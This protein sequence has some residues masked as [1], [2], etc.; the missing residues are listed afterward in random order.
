MQGAERADGLS[1][2][3]ERRQSIGSEASRGNNG[4]GADVGPSSPFTPMAAQHGGNGGGGAAAELVPEAGTSGRGIMA[5]TG[6]GGRGS[7]TGRGSSAGRASGR[8]SAGLDWSPS[9]SST[10]RG[11]PIKSPAARGGRLGGGGGVTGRRMLYSIT[12]VFITLATISMLLAPSRSP[13]ALSM[14]S[15]SGSKQVSASSIVPQS[16]T[17]VA[18]DWRRPDPVVS[19]TLSLHRESTRQ[20][21][22]ES[23]SGP[24]ARAIGLQAHPCRAV[25]TLCEVSHT[26]VVMAGTK[27]TVRHQTS[28]PQG[29]NSV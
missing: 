28:Q 20:P 5:R 6:S 23:F 2:G 25:A 26:T 16:R 8:G 14:A 12:G 13:S 24:P 4:G 9:P 29:G 1:S 11:S 3:I 15:A 21:L 17:A 19:G 7:S 22:L 10:G 27:S 18:D